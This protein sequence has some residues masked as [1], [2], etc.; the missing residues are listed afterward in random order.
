MSIKEKVK[1]LMFGVGFD[2]RGTY[3]QEMKRRLTGLFTGHEETID[4]I[5]S[6][7]E[8]IKKALSV[9]CLWKMLSLFGNETMQMLYLN[10][11]FTG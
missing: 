10:R 2:G 9:Y 5:I 1:R 8:I 3:A 11:I 7:Y 6:D 4:K